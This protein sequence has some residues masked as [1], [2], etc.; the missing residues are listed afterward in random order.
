MCVEIEKVFPVVSYIP[1]SNPT[2]LLAGC[3]L[4]W[5]KRVVFHAFD[6]KVLGRY[7]KV[8]PCQFSDLLV[9]TSDIGDKYFSVIAAAYEQGWIEL[10]P[11]DI[12]LV[13][14]LSKQ[15]NLFH[16]ISIIELN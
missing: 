3:N 7:V 5:V 10:V 11:I 1:Y 15:L 2:I 4:V 8:A 13:L 6:T 14:M 12:A 9:W 16:N